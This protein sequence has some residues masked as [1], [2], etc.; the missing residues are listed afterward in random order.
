MASDVHEIH[1]E[2]K[3][4]TVSEEFAN[5]RKS[6]N[7]IFSDD[8]KLTNCILKL[9]LP[10]NLFLPTVFLILTLFLINFSFS[11]YIYL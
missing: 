11:F 5:M 2:C 4:L 1:H 9:S 8:F 7:Y 6:I 3:P 10:D